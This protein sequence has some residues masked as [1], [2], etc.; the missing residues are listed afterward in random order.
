MAKTR[1]PHL[2][3]SRTQRKWRALKL[4]H[5]GERLVALSPDKADRIPMPEELAAAV[6]EARE[7]HKHGAR[8]RQLQYIGALMRELDPGPIEKALE[9]LS[10]GDRQEVRRFKQ[11][12]RW[13]DALLAGETKVM[14]EVRRACPAV[15]AD[16][17]GCLVAEA[18]GAKTEPGRRKAARVLFRYLKE[19]T[20]TD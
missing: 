1:N 7:M 19:A 17:L 20:I 4:Q 13:R 6:K 18:R 9:G 15:D 16:R 3:M 5:L 2:P 8:R 11:V 10:R 12:E 14:A